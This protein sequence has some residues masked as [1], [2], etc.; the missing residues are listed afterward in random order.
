LFFEIIYA[1][2]MGTY[3]NAKNVESKPKSHHM[4]ASKF[5]EKP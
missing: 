2:P 4:V 3:N 1:Q 5:E